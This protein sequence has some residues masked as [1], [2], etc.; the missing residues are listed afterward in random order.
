MSRQSPRSGTASRND[1]SAASTAGGATPRWAS[2]TTTRVWPST[3]P[4]MGRSDRRGNRVRR[5]DARRPRRASPTPRGRHDGPAVTETLVRVNY[6]E[7]DQM[8]VAYH[9]RYLVWLDIAR[10]E[11]L[12]TAGRVIASWRPAGLRLAVSEV[13]MRYRQPARFDDLVRVRCWVRDIASRRVEFGYAVE[14]GERRPPARHRRDRAARARCPLRSA[15]SPTRHPP[16]PRRAR[17]GPVGLRGRRSKT[18]RQ[19]DRL[20]P[21][22]TRPLSGACLLVPCRPPRARAD[23]PLPRSGRSWSSSRRSSPRRM[24]ESFGPISSAAPCVAPDS[25]VRRMAA[26]AAG[27]DRRLPGDAAAAAAP[28]RCGLHR[29]G[30]RR[31]SPSVCSANRRRRSR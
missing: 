8:G 1:R 16:A 29:P 7:T 6:S 10:T 13:A 2:E 30:R 17:S 4:K 22:R 26:L 18:A 21:C 11:H 28:Q 9:A 25:L 19:R 12:R 3:A 15:G 27:P 5:C 31:R 20:P 14:H 23:R 24:R